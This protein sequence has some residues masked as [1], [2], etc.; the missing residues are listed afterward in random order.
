[1][2]NSGKRERETTYIN[3]F[4]L[5]FVI[6]FLLIVKLP[7]RKAELAVQHK[8]LCCSWFWSQT[9]IQNARGL[10]KP[11]IV[12]SLYNDPWS[13]SLT[14]VP[15]GH[16]LTRS[17]LYP[18]MLQYMQARTNRGVLTLHPAPLLNDGRQEKWKMVLYYSLRISCPW[19]FVFK[20]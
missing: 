18:F 14:L 16:V 7:Q 6:V 11:K 15:A 5:C 12:Q 10:W 8:S 19:C 20:N 2:E 1:M 9:W 4:H 3:P 13:K 17:H